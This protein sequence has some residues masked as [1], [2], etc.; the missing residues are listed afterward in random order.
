MVVITI[1]FQFSKQICYENNYLHTDEY[2]RII[3]NNSLFIIIINYYVYAQ[4]RFRY[5]ERT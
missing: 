1:P 4:T 5:H 3:E 2:K